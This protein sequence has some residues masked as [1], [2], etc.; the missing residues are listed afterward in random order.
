M[1]KKLIFTTAKEAFRRGF[2]KYKRGQ[3]K[4]ERVPYDLVKAD[5]KRSIRGTKF[6]V[7][8]EAKARPG[9]GKKG[10]PKGG[11]P[12]IFGKAYASDKR[13]KGMKIQMMTKQERAA[14]QEAISQSVRKFLKERIGRK[15]KG[16]MQTVKMVK[17]K[18]E[19]ASAAHAGQARALGKVIDKKKLL[20]GGLLTKGIKTAYKAYRKSGR[21]TSDVV[22]KGKTTRA[23]AKSDVK[24]GIRDEIKTK[25]RKVNKDFEKNKSNFLIRRRRLMTIKDLNLLK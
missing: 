3:R 14:N 22:R 19:K 23:I 2:K 7:G 17:R 18:L 4:T 24:S 5:I 13:G 10:L 11:R 16:G 9:I 1:M 12:R 15:K 21:K 25:F 6:F 8:A 20:L